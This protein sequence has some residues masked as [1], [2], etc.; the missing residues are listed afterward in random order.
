MAKEGGG[1]HTELTW[2]IKLPPEMTLDE[3]HHICSVIEE[4][5]EKELGIMTTIHPEALPMPNDD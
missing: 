4:S 3:A 2:H 5:I 1:H